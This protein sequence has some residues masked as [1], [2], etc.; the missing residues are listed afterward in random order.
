MT[1]PKTFPKSGL[2][3]R[4]CQK[5]RKPFM[6][7]RWMFRCNRCKAHESRHSQATFPVRVRR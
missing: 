2:I 6:A 5:C 7:E 3:K 4:D 1:I